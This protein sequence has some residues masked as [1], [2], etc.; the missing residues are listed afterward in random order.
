MTRIGFHPWWHH[1]SLH[2]KQR[3]AVSSLQKPPNCIG[4]IEDIAFHHPV[5]SE[6]L[7]ARCYLPTM[8]LKKTWHVCNACTYGPWH[9]LNLPCIPHP[10]I[11]QQLLWSLPSKIINPRLLNFRSTEWQWQCASAR[12]RIALLVAKMI[13]FPALRKSASA[14]LTPSTSAV[15]SCDTEWGQQNL[16]WYRTNIQGIVGC[17]PNNVPLWEIPI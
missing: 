7:Q 8:A 13:D 6:G 10:N 2:Q 14:S 15:K 4:T 11:L 12:V 3:D 5:K 9:H 16:E 1:G 17:T